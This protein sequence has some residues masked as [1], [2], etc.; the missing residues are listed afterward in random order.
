MQEAVRNRETPVTWKKHCAVGIWQPIHQTNGDSVW[1]ST[2]GTA[3]ANVINS[4]AFWGRRKLEVVRHKPSTF[5][6]T[7]QIATQFESEWNIIIHKVVELKTSV[8]TIVFS[9]PSNIMSRWQSSW[10]H[11]LWHWLTSHI[12]VSCVCCCCVS[13]LYV[14]IYIHPISYI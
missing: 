7:F 8:Q 1:R 11:F 10:I 12:L 3:S 5:L 6:E 14:Y 2:K 9:Q 4:W 13:C